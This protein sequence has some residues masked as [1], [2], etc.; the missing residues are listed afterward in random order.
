M[1]RIVM[2]PN[3]ISKLAIGETVE[4]KSLGIVLIPSDQLCG[5]AP[6]STVAK[7]DAPLCLSC[8]MI[9]SVNGSCYKCENCGSTSGCS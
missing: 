9:M 7:Q 2:A 4:I 8:G 6:V 3:T 1:I 5:K